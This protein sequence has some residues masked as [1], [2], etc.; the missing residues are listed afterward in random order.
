MDQKNKIAYI[1]ALAR[2]VPNIQQEQ[3]IAGMSRLNDV[4]G[5]ESTLIYRHGD[6]PEPS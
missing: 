5:E 4:R 2:H 1:V 3:A 6:A